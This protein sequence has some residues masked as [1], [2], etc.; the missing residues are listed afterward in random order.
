MNYVDK[1]THNNQKIKICKT[2]S[3]HSNHFC[4]QDW[5]F[6]NLESALKLLQIIFFRKNHLVL[7]CF[8]LPMLNITFRSAVCTH[9]ISSSNGDQ[10]I[11]SHFIALFL[12]PWVDVRLPSEIHVVVVNHTTSGYSGRGRHRQILHLKQQGYLNKI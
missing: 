4:K 1:K 11:M 5:N 12:Q 6:Y 2:I 7:A 9:L 3:N 8:S 10:T